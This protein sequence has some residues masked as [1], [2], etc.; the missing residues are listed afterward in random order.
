MVTHPYTMAVVD[1]EGLVSSVVVVE[2]Y[3]HQIQGLTL[4]PIQPDDPNPPGIGW[5]YERGAFAPPA[6]ARGPD[7]PQP[8]ESE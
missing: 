1:Q 5:R 7:N 2:H 4:I 8:D 6:E 3:D